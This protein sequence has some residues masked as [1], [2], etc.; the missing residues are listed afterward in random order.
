[1]LL[2]TLETADPSQARAIVAAPHAR[3]GWNYDYVRR[4]SRDAYLPTRSD[5]QH[6]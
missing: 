3:I 6:R 4:C 2:L 1:M 5:P